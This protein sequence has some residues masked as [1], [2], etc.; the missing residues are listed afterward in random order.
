[1]YHNQEVEVDI[2]ETGTT[3]VSIPH[4]DEWEWSCFI[5][6]VYRVNLCVNKV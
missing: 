3:S 4:P 6:T 2:V 1:M 5:H